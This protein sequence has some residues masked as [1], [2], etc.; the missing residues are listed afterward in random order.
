MKFMTL[1]TTAYTVNTFT[2]VAMLVIASLNGCVGPEPWGEDTPAELRYYEALASAYYPV[3]EERF[4]RGKE[5]H[6]RLTYSRYGK[7][8]ATIEVAE[9]KLEDAI[10]KNR[11]LL[12]KA[13]AYQSGF[14]E[15]EHAGKHHGLK[16]AIAG[17]ESYGH[18][19]PAPE[20]PGE[21]SEALEYWQAGW[22][23]GYRCGYGNGRKQL[24]PYGF[25]LAER[26]Q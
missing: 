18:Y 2:L 7:Q 4:E 23:R 20:V 26:P 22:D 14:A 25:P 13:R 24:R 10:C 21:F 8:F 17:I 1:W 16:D 12:A 19:P 15:A 9:Q 11:A 3:R 5:F 6:R